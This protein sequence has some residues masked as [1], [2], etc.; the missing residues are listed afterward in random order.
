MNQIKK[1]DV[2]VGLKKG[3]KRPPPPPPPK[4]RTPSKADLKNSV[5]VT[6]YGINI[7]EVS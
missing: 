3:E 2:F 5:N 7:S 4:P 1:V 6:M